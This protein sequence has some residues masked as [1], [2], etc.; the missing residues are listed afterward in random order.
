[1]STGGCSQFIYRNLANSQ[2]LLGVLKFFVLINDSDNAGLNES[3][4]LSG[5][6]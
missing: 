4:E 5:R 6:K 1:M 2:I 3:K